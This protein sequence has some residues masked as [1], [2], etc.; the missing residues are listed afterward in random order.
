MAKKHRLRHTMAGKAELCARAGVLEWMDRCF[1]VM[2]P[3][4]DPDKILQIATAMSKM[5]NA[6]MNV[7]KVKG[8]EED[9]DSEKKQDDVGDVSKLLD[10][11]KSEV[12]QGKK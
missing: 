1:K 11:I 9:E 3:T 12:V 8:K 6:Q 5:T 7:R 4:G 2:E 10:V